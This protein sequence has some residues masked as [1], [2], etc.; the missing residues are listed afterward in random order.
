VAAAVRVRTNARAGA[1]SSIA[2]ALFA[3]APEHRPWPI[4][5][6]LHGGSVEQLAVQ[7]HA[8]ARTHARMT[9]IFGL[10]CITIY[11]SSTTTLVFFVMRHTIGLRMTAEDEI[12]GSDWIEHR[13]QSENLSIKLERALKAVQT[14]EKN[15]EHVFIELFKKLLNDVGIKSCILPHIN[16]LQTHM[17]QDEMPHVR[18]VQP[19]ISVN[20]F[21]SNSD[22]IVDRLTQECS[23]TAR[24][25]HRT[26]SCPE[27]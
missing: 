5:G 11:I 3:C 7:V 26:P 18:G 10:A 4:M 13:V 17:A 9:Q 6:V 19:D 21:Y 16:N 20:S 22:S 24:L 1:W 27:F 8:R 12:L 14:D 2:V 15:P 25:I 23:P